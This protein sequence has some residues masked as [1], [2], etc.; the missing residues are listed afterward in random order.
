MEGGLDGGGATTWK[1]G[2]TKCDSMMG[3]LEGVTLYP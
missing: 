3:G 1:E 2:G